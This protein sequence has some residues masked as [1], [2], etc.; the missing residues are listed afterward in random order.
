MYA[1]NYT[2]GVEIFQDVDFILKVRKDCHITTT[3]IQDSTKD[4]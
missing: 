1:I 4:I 3:Y 2:K